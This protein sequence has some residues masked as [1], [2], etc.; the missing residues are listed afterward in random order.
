M[1]FRLN[2][3]SH[4]PLTSMPSMLLWRLCASDRYHVAYVFLD[5][6]SKTRWTPF[7]GPVEHSTHFSVLR[8][9]FLRFSR[10]TARQP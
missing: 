7:L 5:E 8:T 1:S 2:L 6:Y 10:L 4:L 9:R 3:I